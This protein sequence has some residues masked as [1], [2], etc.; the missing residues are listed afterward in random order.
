VNSGTS[1][2]AITLVGSTSASN[3]S[4]MFY[5]GSFYFD[6]NADCVDVSASS[7]FAFGTGDFT[8]ECWVNTSTYSTDTV[9]RRIFMTDGP[10]GNASGNFQL[11]IDISAGALYLWSNTGDLD[12][13]TSGIVANGNW[14]HIAACRSGSTLR[15]FVNGIQVGSTTYSGSISPNSGTPRPR[16]GNYDGSGGGGDFSGYIQDVR[17]YKGLA[18]YTQNFIPASTDP[19]ILPDTPSGVSYTSNLIPTTDGAISSGPSSTYLTLA[20]SADF[21]FGTGDFTV[22]FFVYETSKVYGSGSNPRAFD[23]GGTFQMVLLI[24]SDGGGIRI[25]Y[26]DST[27]MTSNGTLF[28]NKWNHISLVRSGSTLSLYINGVFDKSVSNSTNVPTPSSTIYIGR[29]YGSDSGWINGFLSNFH[30]VKGTALYTANFTPPTGPI[31][32]VANT[33]LLC[34]K[35]NSSATAFDVSPGT[36]TANGNA[37]ATNF[38]PFTV[39]INT[40]RGK[41]SGYCTW[42]PL[43]FNSSGTLSN[44][45]LQWAN[46]S[47][48]HYS[49]RS[50]FSM[51]TGKWYAEGT[52]LVNTN[53]VGSAFGIALRTASLSSYTGDTG[54]WSYHS[55]GNKYL[56]GASGVSFGIAYGTTVGNVVGLAFDA[57]NGNLDGY[58][59]GVY[60]GRVVS[61]L[62]SN[63]YFWMVNSYNW[64]WATNFGQKPFKFP[65]PAGF[66]PLALA[67]TPRPT[68]VRPDQ[69]VGVTTYTGTGAASRPVTNLG[70]KPD[71]VWIK[72]RSSGSYSHQLFDSVRGASAGC[73]YS[74]LTNAQDSN[75]PITSFDTSGFTLGSSASLASQSYGSQNGSG[76]NYVGWAWKAG[77]NSN[78]YNINDVGYATASAAGLTAGS[79]TPT[80]ASV[81]TKSGFSIITWTRA[82]T[83]DSISHGLGVAP[84]FIIC[85]SKS[86]DIGWMIGHAGLDSTSPWNYRIFFD[87]GARNSD[88]DTSWNGVPTSSV[89]YTGNTGYITGNMVAYCWAEIP[90]FSKFGSYTGNGSADGPMVITG[91]RPRWIMYKV[92]SGDTGHWFIHDTS[93]DPYNEAK[94]YLYANLSNAEATSVF[95]PLDILSNGFKIRSSNININGS[96]FGFVYAAFA[97][98]PTQNLYGAQSN[99]R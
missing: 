10:T 42:N 16:I 6:G 32:S 71:F 43:D 56:N 94:Y 11:I 2:K 34:C 44:G 80:G 29:Y 97:E 78:T 4:S 64:T 57:D 23:F 7:D 27:L 15:A 31:S 92:Y 67:N 53:S 55:N 49:V 8:V 25:D 5:G 21:G 91:F 73:L 82:S 62:S 17:I 93:R 13:V 76:S 1:N 84:K 79:I 83:A 69:F 61:G 37:V 52:V 35:S 65:P 60:Q 58:L 40:Q 30:V 46:T 90:G 72:N 98:T 88:G 59:N 87:T 96:G 85:K 48:A 45:N 74:D 20:S 19:D 28:V 95:Y 51:K 75:F 18:K 14:N 3:S 63:D 41:Q 36:I 12:Y 86:N 26:A 70:F 22:E 54:S 9:Y 24:P 68:I 99:A 38:N 81:N 39:N 77:G 66:Q 47:D 50:S 89:F 33:K